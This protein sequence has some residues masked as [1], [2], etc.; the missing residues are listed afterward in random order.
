AGRGLPGRAADGQLGPPQ[1]LSA[2]GPERPGRGRRGKA[3]GARGPRGALRAPDPLL[4][5][6]EPPWSAGRGTGRPARSRTPRTTPRGASRFRPIAEIRSG[7]QGWP[8]R[9]PGMVVHGPPLEGGADQDG[10]DLLPPL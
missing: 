8:V 7:G 2:A 9:A 4:G 6:A 3:P 1:D 10:S 5:P